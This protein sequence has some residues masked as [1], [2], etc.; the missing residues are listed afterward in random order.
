MV[1]NDF[2]LFAPGTHAFSTYG[3]TLRFHVHGEGPVCVAHPGGPGVI[4]DYLRMP[5]VEEF[6]TVV[7][8]EPPGTTTSSRLPS[9]PHGYTRQ[10]Y[11]DVLDRLIDHLN[12]ERVYL[13]GHSHGGF[14]VQRYAL[15][16]PERVRGLILYE[17]AAATGED[18]SVETARQLHAF[19][20]RNAGNPR[21]EAAVSALQS[22]AAISDDAELTAALRGLFPTYVAD[23]WGREPDFLPVRDSIRVVH[24]SGRDADMTDD[25]IDDRAALPT[26]RVPTLVIVGRYDVMCG[27]R[28]ANELHELIPGSN[29]VILEFSGHFGHVEEPVAFAGAVAKFVDYTSRP[30]TEKSITDL[31]EARWSTALSPRMAEVMPALVRLRCRLRKT[32]KSPQARYRMLLAWDHQSSTSCSE[33]RTGRMPSPNAF[34]ASVLRNI[35]DMLKYVSAILRDTSSGGNDA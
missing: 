18:H 17:S 1:S 31:A 30:G 29:M 19:G 3:L 12:Q 14:V 23:Y 32:A 8:L 35:V 13:L 10:L 21:A 2:D 7:Y 22:V 5:E 20:V 4:W 16:H 28:W 33:T 27:T 25:L 26:L 11:S 34:P 24:I 9:H 15:N 6:M